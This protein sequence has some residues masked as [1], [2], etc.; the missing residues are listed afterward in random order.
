MS[1]TH[2]LRIQGI[3]F[4]HVYFEKSYSDALRLSECME[5]SNE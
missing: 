1:A 5:L 2:D 4:F 3:V